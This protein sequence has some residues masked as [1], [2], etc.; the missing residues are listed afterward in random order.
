MSRTGCTVVCAVHQ[1]SSPMTF[2][3]DDMLIMSQ[4]RC[5]YCGP[6]ERILDFFKDAGYDCPPFY[7]LAEFGK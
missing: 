6:R 4:G 1:P 2:C 7:N 3:F 5:R